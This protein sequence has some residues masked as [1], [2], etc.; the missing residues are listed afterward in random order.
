MN[1]EKLNRI[2]N[3]INDHTEMIG[4]LSK[5]ILKV[6]NDLNELKKQ[7]NENIPS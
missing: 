5:L 1:N 7:V 6:S 3:L 2:I 4:R